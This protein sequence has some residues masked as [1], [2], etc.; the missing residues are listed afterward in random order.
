VV[1]PGVPLEIGP[2]ASAR[3]K[4]IP[5]IGELEL[6]YQFVMSYGSCL[7]SKDKLSEKKL[8]THHS[9]LITFLAITGSNGKSTTTTL[10]DH[11]MR[12]AGFNTM[13]GGNIGNALTEE[14]CKAVMSDGLCVMSKD[15]EV[16]R[17]GASAGVKTNC[18]K[19][20]HHALRITHHLLLLSSRFRVSS[21]TPS[22]ASGRI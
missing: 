10:L 14:I 19:K 3:A 16:M 7:M 18:L 8:I 21:L 2:I 13:L 4:G 20:T 6:A 17:E 22:T 5:V 11:M 1:S 9:S 12:K 15:K